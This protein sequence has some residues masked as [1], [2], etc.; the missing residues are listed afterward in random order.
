MT[1]S[2]PRASQELKIMLS[3]VTCSKEKQPEFQCVLTPTKGKPK[4]DDVEGFLPQF[5]KRMER[6]WSLGLCLLGF[7][8]LSLC[9]LGFCS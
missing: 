3:S 9:S 1:V 7:C 5:S 8:S 4:K 6:V 2:R